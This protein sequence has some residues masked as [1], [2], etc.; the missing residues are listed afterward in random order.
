MTRKKKGRCVDCGG[1]IYAE[2]TRCR[3]CSWKYRKRRTRR[4]YRPHPATVAKLAH[5]WE[6]IMSVPYRVSA[7]WLFYR[8]LQDGVYRGKRDYSRF[9]LMIAKARKRYYEGW[10][11]DALV[12]ES[13]GAH[14][15]GVGFSSEDA[16]FDELRGER[17]HLDRWLG[18]DGYGVICFEANAMLSQFEYY[19]PAAFSLWP[20]RGDASIEYKWRLAQY[21]KRARGRHQKPITVFYFGDW[22]PKG[23]EI[24]ESAMR[25]VWRWSR[26]DFE[27]IRGGLNLDHPAR[28]DLPENFEKPGEYQW[29]ALT[30]EDAKTL[31]AETLGDFYDPAKEAAL[32][33]REEQAT[34]AFQDALDGLDL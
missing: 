6:H 8:L 14:R 32:E 1:A 3:P 13:R 2:A 28:F 22:D 18:Q 24:P 25:D 31:I 5:A 21:I 27:F 19:A 20:F 15:T 16:W 7:R 12:D 34:R 17:C 30:D 9:S 33:E 10:R 23:I 11:P 4:E 26:V 29:E